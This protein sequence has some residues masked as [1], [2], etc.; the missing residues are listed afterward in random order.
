MPTNGDRP[1]V[2][3]GMYEK[4]PKLYSRTTYQSDRVCRLTW[5]KAGPV[6]RMSKLRVSAIMCFPTGGWRAALDPIAAVQLAKA[7]PP[8]TLVL[9]A[10][11][12]TIAITAHD[13]SFIPG[14]LA[15]PAV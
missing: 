1:H 7:I 6:R 11:A 12:F 2:S 5:T 15:I 13:D 8:A 14:L 3:T 9:M 4:S 10:A